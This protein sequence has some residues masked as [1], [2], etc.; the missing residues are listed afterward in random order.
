MK[1]SFLLIT[2][3]VFSTLAIAQK[4]PSTNPSTL[5][6]VKDK[7]KQVQDALD[8][9]T[10]EQKKMMGQMGMSTK[11]PAMPK[12]A[13][14]ADIKAAVDG[15]LGVPS[16]NAALMAAI[17]KI[18]ITETNLAGYLTDANKY[19]AIH[20]SEEGK[21]AGETFYMGLKGA[22]FDAT[23]IANN[24]TGLWING[25]LEPAVYILG[26]VTA[27]DIMDT[28]NISNLAAMLSMAGAPHIALPLLEYLSKKI[29][30]NTTILNNLGQAWFYLGE[31]EKANAQLEKAVKAFAYHPQANYTQCLIQQSKGN[32]AQAIG[33]IKNSL[34]YSVSLHK[35]NMLRKMGYKIKSSDM[36]KPFHPDPNPLGLKNIVRPEVPKDYNSELKLKAEWDAFVEQC[37]NRMSDFTKE[38]QTYM[39]KTNKQAMETYGKL[40]GKTANEIVAAASATTKKAE[41]RSVYA[42]MADINLNEMSRDGGIRYRLNNFKDKCETLRKGYT[43][44]RQDA[45]R[46][47]LEKQFATYATEETEEAKKG[48]NTGVDACKVKRAYSDWVYASFNNPAE[49]AY[50]EYLH[51]L[52][53]KITEELY[54][55]QFKYSPEEFE[56]QKLN[57]KIEWLGA[58]SSRYFETVDGP[59][60]CREVVQTK[61]NYKLA[62]FED[63]NCKYHSSL[64]FGSGNSIETHCSKMTVNFSGGPLSGT[65]NYRSGSN[66]KDQLVNGNVEATVIEKSV[67]AGPVQAGA[68]AGMGME[69][70]GNGIE[71]VYINGEASAMNVTA[72]GKMS[73]ISGSMSGGI[74]G[75]GK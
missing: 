8:K 63:M 60:Q 54:W 25:E 23:A 37:R 2:C 45:K 42:V 72:S 3:I 5:K 65:L 59:E 4:K 75:F 51:Q 22:G 1:K 67:G 46:R 32:T 66:G 50:K 14:D 49:E 56:Q 41:P 74:S 27:V 38:L 70:T 52:Y 40:K 36:R 10:P 44:A 7:Q 16:K 61:S 11:V 68:K 17:P 20:L 33:K 48:E 58:L 30:D 47:E 71:D 39:S 29:P 31:I 19:I 21:A 64:N 9:L 28:D 35:I 13:T 73:L 62:D 15:G 57:A 26:K 18:T 6:E 53:I 34:Q 24:A 43:Q 12:G 55:Q 69:F